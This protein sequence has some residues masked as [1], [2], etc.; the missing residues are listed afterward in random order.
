MRTQSLNGTWMYRIGRGPETPREVPFSAL[1]VGH[2][3]CR[4]SFVPAQKAGI[5][6]L[7]F[8]GITY[9]AQV[10]LNDRLL[11]EML[12]YCEYEF[13]ISDI[14]E[15]THGYH[16]IMRVEPDMEEAATR[17]MDMQLYAEFERRV[18]EAD[19]SYGKGYDKIAYSDFVSVPA[20]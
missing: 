7:K 11:G 15:S 17:A 20:E 8:D 5:T 6:L 13:E 12:P 16:I 3:E 2:S 1:A 14:V 19:I 18:A 9:Y 10:F 4:R